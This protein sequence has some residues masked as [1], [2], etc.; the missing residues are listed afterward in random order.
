MDKARLISLGLSNREAEAYLVLLKVPDASAS[1]ISSKTNES[2][3]NTYDTLS[4]LIKKGLVSYVIKNNVKYFM[5][6]SPKRLTDW[7]ELKK[8]ELVA[9]EKEVERLLPDLLKLRT[10]F[11]K[12]TTVEVYEGIGGLRTVLNETVDSCVKSGSE[13]LVFGALAHKLR[14]LDPIFHKKYY[15]RRQQFGI[16]TRYIFL[17]GIVPPKAPLS[18]YRYLPKH[19]ESFVA[20]AIHGDEVSF[21]LLTEPQ[22]TVLVKSKEFAQSYKSN[23]EELWKIA[24][25]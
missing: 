16:K 8:A 2:R 25:P 23:F 1:T 18:T 5:A 20:T 15:A 11:E 21:W 4:S 19:Y 14:E 6:S 10:G 22:I 7:K 24:K 9:Q 12:K 3:T 13:F 17:E